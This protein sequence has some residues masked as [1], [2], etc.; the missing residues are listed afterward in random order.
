MATAYA[1]PQQL[2]LD[3]EEEP[4]NVTFIFYFFKFIC[5]EKYVSWFSFSISFE[6]ITFL[7]DILNLKTESWNF[8]LIGFHQ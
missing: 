3:E 4:F 2:A 8:L 6:R 5:V 7:A 1:A